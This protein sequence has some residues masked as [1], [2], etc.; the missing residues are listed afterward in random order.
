MIKAIET[1]YR[2]YRFRSRLE[3]RWAVFF[4]YLGLTWEYEKQGFSINGQAYLPDFWI[5]NWN[6]WVEI[7]PQDGTQQGHYLCLGLS[8][9][10][11]VVLAR[12]NPWRGEHS[13]TIYSRGDVMTTGRLEC[14][15]MEVE[16]DF[17][18]GIGVVGSNKTILLH[19]IEP[20]EDKILD[21]AF[22]AAC[23]ARFEHGEYGYER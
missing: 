5:K 21:E 15:D 4:D 13:M 16:D 6:A 18:V 9:E 20:W 14:I 2:G 19:N 22:E 11:K 8:K 12:G 23:H 10:Y 3:A 7:K 1:R 17:L